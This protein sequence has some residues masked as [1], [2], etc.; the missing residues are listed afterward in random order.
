MRSRHRR[1]NEASPGA[2]VAAYAVLAFMHLPVLVIVLYAFTTADRTYE[3]PLPG[4]TLH[5]F[6]A[7]F[8][9]SDIWAAMRLSLLVAAVATLVA[10]ILGSLTALGMARGNFRGKESIT[11]LLVLPI[12]LPGIVTGIALLAELRF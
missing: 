9:R 2:R 8:A 11:L 6:E 10:I 3:F 4:L 7:A 5:W 1:W 12:A